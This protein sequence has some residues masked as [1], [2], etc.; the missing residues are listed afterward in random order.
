MADTYDVV[1]LVEQALS[2]ADAA[3]VHSLHQGIRVVG[4]HARRL[5][6]K[7]LDSPGVAQGTLAQAPRHART[8]H[9][10]FMLH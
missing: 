7:L 10:A 6:G 9:Y 2:A 1:L 5:L 3:R 8:H 4:R